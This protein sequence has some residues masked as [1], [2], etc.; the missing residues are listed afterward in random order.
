MTQSSNGS[1]KRKGR[2]AVNNIYMIKITDTLNESSWEDGGQRRVCCMKVEGG[3]GRKELSP[4]LLQD[5][6]TRI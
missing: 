3:Q 4:L 6:V 1:H 2:V 5:D